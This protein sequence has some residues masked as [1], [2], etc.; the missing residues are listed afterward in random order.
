MTAQRSMLK[1]HDHGF[2]S[3]F[4]KNKVYGIFFA[5]RCFMRGIPVVSNAFQTIDTKIA[6]SLSI[7]L[8]AFDETEMR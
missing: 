4:W 7:V 8:I 6:N 3:C 2:R 5:K 1:S